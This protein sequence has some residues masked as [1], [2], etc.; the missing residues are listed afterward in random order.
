M[1][2]PA[3]GIH[4]PLTGLPDRAAFRSRLESECAQN[5]RRRRPFGLILVDIDRFKTVNYGYGE[6]QGNALLVWLAGR[7]QSEL[8]AGD[9]LSRW[10]GQE[11]LCLLP[12]AGKATLDNIAERL[13]QAIQSSTVHIGDLDLRVTASLGTACFP[14]NGDNLDRLLSACGAAL[15][16]AKSSGRNRVTSA[17]GIRPPLFGIGRLLNQALQ[18]GRVMPAYQPVVD[19]KSGEVVAE[20]A[21]ARI[22][23]PNNSLIPASAFID[24][25]R[26][27]QLADRIDRAI[28]L[29]TLTRCLDERRQH[30]PRIRLANISGNLLHHPGGLTGL[31]DEARGNGGGDPASAMRSLVLQVTG[32]DLPA[33]TDKTCATLRPFLDAGLRLALSGFGGGD[34][35]FRNLADL[36]LSLLR[37]EGGLIRRVAEPRV[38]AAVR[39]IRQTAADLGLLTLA[40]H[41]ENEEIANIVRDLGIDWGQGYYFGAPALPGADDNG[42]Q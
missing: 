21:L 29:P 25:A 13:R 26:A 12:D 5:A 10:S 16:H 33:D 6:Q 19:L 42:K 20:E 31:L 8:R 37:I 36:P 30:A 4:D 15:Q 14:E 1:A 23:S 7:I 27:L 11:F 34:S 35:S 2:T 22:V 32:H 17:S 39:G 28:I 3:S 18:D 40:E 24:V 41:V 9:L 38:R